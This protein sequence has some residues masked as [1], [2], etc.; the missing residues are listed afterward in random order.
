MAKKY[1]SLEDAIN[2]LHY[3]ADESCAS[4]VS[5]FEALPAA[6]VVPSGVYDQVKW[7]RDLAIYQLRENY[8]VGL[9][10]VK[11]L[12]GVRMDGGKENE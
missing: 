12:C 5:D 3:N 11:P 10:Q 6:D 8:G 4:V 7:E 9:G 1:I 2:L